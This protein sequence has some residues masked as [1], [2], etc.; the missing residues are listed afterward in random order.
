MSPE[1]LVRMANQIA[2]FFTNRPD[3]EAEAA[4]ADHLK[5]FWEKRMLAQIFAYL[6]AGGEGLQPRVRAA[7]THLRQ[8][9]PKA[10]TH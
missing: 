5:S 9:T 1:K 7:L 3:D 6:D 4:I 8:A 10:Q 2:Q